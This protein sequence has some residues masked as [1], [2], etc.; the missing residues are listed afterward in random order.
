M[1]LPQTPTDGN[2]ARPQNTFAPDIAP[3]ARL[4]PGGMHAPAAPPATD[5][6]ARVA[7]VRVDLRLNQEFDYLV[8]PSLAASAVPGARVRVP[9]GRRVLQ[10][11]VLALR[12]PGARLPAELALKPIYEVIGDAPVLSAPVLQLARW[13]SE[14]YLCPLD[15]CLRAVAPSVV[16]RRATLRKVRPRAD[17]ELEE[18]AAAAVASQPLPLTGAQAAALERVL[19]ATREK[20]PRPVLLFGVTGSGKTEVYLQ[21]IAEV[22]RAGRGAIVLVPE[23]SLTPQTVE[24]FRSRFVLPSPPPRPPTGS[25][26]EP[27]A[28]SPLATAPSPIGNRQS[29]TGNVLAVL[30]SGL[31]QGERFREWQRIR[32]GEARVVVGARSAV[33]APVRD[34]GLIVVD[35]EH[36]PAYKQEEM[37]RYHAR[38]VAVMRGRLEGAAVLL[39]S[40]TPSLESFRNA[41]EGKY[42][43]SRLPERVDGRKLPRVRVVDMRVEIIRQKGL[44]VFSQSLHGAILSRLERGEQVIL[45]LNRRG[46]SASLLCRKCGFVATCPECSVALSYHRA[47]QKLLCHFCGHQEPAPSRCPKPE[48]RDP[49][50]RF[51]GFGTEKLEEAVKACFPQARVARMDSDTMLGRADYERTLLRFRMGRLDVLLGTQ[52]IAKGL[53][54]PRVT[55]VGIIYADLGLHVPDFRS[56]ERTFQQV[57]QV[58]GRAGRGD[59]EGEVIVQSFTPHHSAIQFGRRQDYEGFYEEESGFRRQL[60]Y[61]PF[62]HLTKLEF[63]SA[64]ASK[65][66]FAARRFAE[67]LARDAG[68]GLR[69]LGPCPAPMPRLRGRHR[70]HLLL[71]D[72]R[73]KGRKD[74]LRKLLDAWPRDG[75]VRVT[76]D[77]DPI[78]ML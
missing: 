44:S 52:M 70:F 35:E 24:R 57:T 20:A 19:L 51:Q 28:E 75:D 11:T 76:V 10:G 73:R 58:A 4:N 59:L 23:I 26:F 56:G 65:A 30:H 41:R 71:R 67:A 49:S 69:L 1:R 8:P 33:F 48:C 29:A 16:Q 66:E 27:G 32:S 55:L 40:A 47:D 2:P 12:A 17:A 18:A 50:I 21:A 22:L 25:L 37:P 3:P 14:Y 38:D 68:P 78:Q 61:P 39:G 36:E 45:Y 54:F 34:L 62:N 15:L 42:A 9:F 63:T 77:V 5:A 74:D 13:M 60:D 72:S 53:D 46:Y 6:L 43:L 7:V 64:Q 31:S